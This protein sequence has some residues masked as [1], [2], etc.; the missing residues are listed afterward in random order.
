[1]KN[2]PLTVLLQEIPR[3]VARKKG[4]DN[5]FSPLVFMVSSGG[6]MGKVRAFPVIERQR[7]SHADK[8]ISLKSEAA[9]VLA[10]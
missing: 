5:A 2:L 1:M 3:E 6:G 8:R 10:E 9:F 4:G 7:S